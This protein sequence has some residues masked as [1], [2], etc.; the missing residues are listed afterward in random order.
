MARCRAFCCGDGGGG[1][2]GVEV[3][4]PGLLRGRTVATCGVGRWPGLRACECDGE[5]M[6]RRWAVIM[7]SA[8][9]ASDSRVE[10]V[11]GMRRER[12][13][14]NAKRANAKVK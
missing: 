5:Q 12:R 10:E 14:E 13:R 9:G 2:S 1:E 4:R 11:E 6:R 3:V 7:I 8:E